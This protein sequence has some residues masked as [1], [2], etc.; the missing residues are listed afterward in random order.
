MSESI[1]KQADAGLGFGRN[2]VAVAFRFGTSVRV[3]VIE[4]LPSNSRRSADPTALLGQP[5]GLLTASPQ[6][7]KPPPAFVSGDRCV[8]NP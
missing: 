3:E 6:P 4:G 2:Q 5:F 7:E 8:G 1:R